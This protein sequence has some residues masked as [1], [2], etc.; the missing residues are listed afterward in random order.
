MVSDDTTTTALV[1]AD[2]DVI[3]AEREF[4]QMVGEA[5]SD[6]TDELPEGYKVTIL[7][8]YAGSGGRD[9]IVIGTDDLRL[10]TAALAAAMARQAVIE[11]GAAHAV[12]DALMEDDGPAK[13]RNVNAAGIAK[14][15]CIAPGGECYK[16]GT[17][18]TANCCCAPL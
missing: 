7:A 10:A 3:E 5:I 14:D 4:V 8:R 16:P 13:A 18:R 2:R 9:D 15:E 17:C 1:V 6:L 11:P 12:L